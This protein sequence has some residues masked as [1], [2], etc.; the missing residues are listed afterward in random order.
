MEKRQTK[1][2]TAQKQAELA[3]EKVNQK[4]D[5]LGMET[6]RLYTKMNALQAQFDAIRN[7]PG[8][9]RISYERLKKIRL[10][11][12]Q[13]AEKIE[14][15]FKR[16]TVKNTGGGIIGVSAGVAVAAL[17]PTAAMGVAT[18]FGVASTGTAISALSG[19]AA[20][21][22]ALA[23][24]G[25][26]AL[27]VGG[28]GIAAGKVLLV[29]AGPVGWAI[30][31]VAVI[32][33]GI[34]LFKNKSEKQRL[35][36][37]FALISKRDEKNYR[38][39]AVELNERILRIQNE[40]SLLDKAVSEV[41]TFGVDYKRMTRKQ[42]YTLGAYFNLM[43][44]STQL[45]I[46]PI[47]HLQ[48]SYTRSDFE[49]F[50]SLQNHYKALNCKRYE[51]PLITLANLFYGIVLEEEDSELLIRAFKKNRVFLDSIK[52]SKEEMNAELFDWMRECLAVKKSENTKKNNIYLKK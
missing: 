23:W 28:G 12:K 9:K 30:A 34:L 25:G 45:L 47:T 13:Q 5:Q 11:W 21:N 15:D 4:I 41:Q 6:G 22:A 39:A 32:G 43:Q 16:A 35:E 37:I 44:A 2:P 27:A 51:Q 7:V 18:T 8:E 14:A 1:L 10:N 31:G 17:G 46:N 52:V 50:L 20:T 33:S 19:A 48:P 38:L 26:G 29:L 3:L 49:K 40:C 42:Q 24:L 36:N